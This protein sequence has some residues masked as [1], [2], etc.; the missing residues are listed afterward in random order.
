MTLVVWVVIV[1]ALVSVVWLATGILAEPQLSA[2]VSGD[3]VVARQ[4]LSQLLAASRNP[5]QHSRLVSFTEAELNALLSR[6]LAEVAELPLT[7]VQFRLPA[8]GRAEVAGRVPVAA[9]L[10]EQP[11]NRLVTLLPSGWQQTPVWVRFRLQV[12]VEPVDDGRR[13][14]M[15]L[16]IERF[17][18]GRRRLPAVLPR[19]MLT[20]ATLRV[21]HLRLPDSVKDVSVQTGRIDVIKAGKP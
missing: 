15:R 4:K 2:I 10:A 12:S 20:P 8:A 18:L 11:F 19:L 5:P 16:R 3:E 7:R 1:G 14:Y 6:R 9:L 13:R 17:W 21:L